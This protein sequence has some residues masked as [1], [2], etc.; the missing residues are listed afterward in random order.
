MG[1]HP[2]GR[3][4]LIRFGA[5]PPDDH[6]RV[7]VGH[8]DDE[9]YVMLTPDADMWEEF[10]RVDGIDIVAVWIRPGDRSMPFRPSCRRQPSA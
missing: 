10:V 8:I 1:D 5:Q 2:L 3:G 6:A 9:G 7:I 4:L